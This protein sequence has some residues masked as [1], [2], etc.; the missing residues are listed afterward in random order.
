MK[1]LTEFITSHGLGTALAIYT[2]RLAEFMISFSPENSLIIPE[3]RMEFSLL[4][5][6]YQNSLSCNLAFA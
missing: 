5:A 4:H 2:K 1:S 6:T 3:T